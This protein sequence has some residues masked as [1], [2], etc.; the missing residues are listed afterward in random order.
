M[1][2]L[3]VA[4]AWIAALASTADAQ[5]T[6]TTFASGSV[7]EQRVR[8][9]SEVERV[10]GGVWGAGVDVSMSDWLS[11]RG[12]IAGGNLSARTLDAERRSLTESELAVILTPDDWIALD[13]T[14]VVR[15][16]QTTLATQ[17]WVELR[18]GG[19]LGMDIIEGMVRGTVR[20]SISPAVSVSGHPSPDLALGVGTGLEFT[21][22]RLRTNLDYGLD[23]YD[24]PAE[25]GERRLEQLSALT[26]RVS[27]RVR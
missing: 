16:M 25:G 11:L 22:G 10:G 4:A 24:F 3:I 20:L 17:R 6:Y 19:A 9:D 8:L 26:V 14:A 27:W 13:A 5:R 7:V 21:S 2:R 18:T 15:T 12:S 1:R 23:R